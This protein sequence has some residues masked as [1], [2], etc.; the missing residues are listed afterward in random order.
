MSRI[1]LEHKT[2]FQISSVITKLMNMT[3]DVRASTSANAEI[4]AFVIRFSDTYEWVCGNFRGLV[5]SNFALRSF[6]AWYNFA[7]CYF[8]G[9]LYNIYTVNHYVI[10][11]VT[12]L[13]DWQHN[14]LHILQISQSLSIC[15]VILRSSLVSSPVP[16]L[17]TIRQ[18]AKYS[19]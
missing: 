12:W 13:E 17:T 2:E 11:R 10:E 16:A 15:Y 9:A 19:I 8:K 18:D 14:T 4:H 3:Q 5:I 1:N 7:P 6:L